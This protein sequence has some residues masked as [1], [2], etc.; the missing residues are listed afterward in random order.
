MIILD[1]PKTFEEFR[2]TCR[3]LFHKNKKPD[4]IKFSNEQY[5]LFSSKE[6]TEQPQETTLQKSF[7]IK[8]EHLQI[9]ENI[10]HHRSDDI[11]DLLYRILWNLKEKGPNFLNNAAHPDVIDCQRRQKQISR[12]IHKM[13]AF[14]RFRKIDKARMLEKE[15]DPKKH[16]EKNQA[17]YFMAWHKPEHKI[18]RKGAT[19]FKKRFPNMHWSILSP[20]ECVHW[21]GTNLSYS[22]GV[23][24]DPLEDNSDNF[25]KWWLT[26][27]EAIFNPARVKIKAMKNEMPTKY[28]D[29]MPETQIISR[30]IREA[31][32][33]LKEMQIKAQQK[34]LPIIQGTYE[35]IKNKAKN[36]TNCPISCLGG[37]TVFGEGN[38][39]AEI[40]IV[41]EQ[42]GDEEDKAQ[43]VFTGPSGQLLN[44]LLEECDLNRKHLYLTN[45]VKHFK[46]EQKGNKRI[47]KTPDGN[48]IL[49]CRNWL[50]SEIQLI[51]P[52]IIICLG[53]VAAQSVLGIQLKISSA[54]K[55]TYSGQNNSKVL[56]TYHPSSILRANSPKLKEE[57]KQQLLKT[58]LQGKSLLT[59]KTEL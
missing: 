38:L 21:N 28:W 57:Q 46:W 27:Y 29:S 48:E 5:N 10:S 45:A 2:N 58:L 40:M 55:E 59:Q 23:S 42:T 6:H 53:R 9:L 51:K 7:F 15:H 24:K 44:Q 49:S 22:E 34:T 52:K 26:Y 1:T 33:R 32:T 43:R 11:W 37:S 13:H 16:E 56:V 12:D 47:H 14:V 19:F 41:G 18:I 3:T 36:C 30:L 8:K 39:K 25:E 20:D 50:Q 17:E 54:I 31:P 35:E 4:S